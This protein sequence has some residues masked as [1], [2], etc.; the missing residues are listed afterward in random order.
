MATREGGAKK[1][2]GARIAKPSIDATIVGGACV[3]A[4]AGR[5]RAVLAGDVPSGGG[6]AVDGYFNSADT[7]KSAVDAC[8]SSS[9]TVN[10]ACADGAVGIADWNVGDV[11]SMRDMFAYKEGF[12]ADLSRWNTKSVT[13]MRDMF[14]GAT[15][16]NGDMPNWNVEAVTNMGQVF[17]GA[18]SFNGDISNWNPK[19]VTSMYRTFYG[20]TSFNGDISNWNVEKATDM[21]AMFNGATSF[22]GDMPNWNVEKVTA[23][24]DMFYGATNFNGDISNWNPKA[25]K[26][27]NQMFRDA[28]SFNGDISAWNIQAVTD[29]SNMFNNARAFARDITGWNAAAIA[30][31][32]DATKVSGMFTN[33]TAWRA[34]YTN[35][36]TSY[37]SVNDGPPHLWTAGAAA[38]GASVAD[39][40]EWGV[41]LVALSLALSTI[42]SIVVIERALCAPKILVPAARWSARV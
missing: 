12:N 26:D 11:T 6:S 16:F 1:N 24:R 31:A 40:P 9:T 42:T 23:M 34:I 7:L 32:R 28:T 18:T 19:A 38:P 22:N 14:R 20:A 5:A 37:F 36:Q 3:V 15:S 10:A 17:S 21:T 33:A 2:R 30:A 4:L 8:W 13:Y 25:V 35:T 41:A 39:F 27:M 29:M